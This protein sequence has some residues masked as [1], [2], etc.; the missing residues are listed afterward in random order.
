ML[1]HAADSTEPILLAARLRRIA[2]GAHTFDVPVYEHL[3]PAPRG[4]PAAL[5]LA[6]GGSSG[7]LFARLIE[8][9]AA[10]GVRVVAFDFP[11]HTPEGLLGPRTPAVHLLRNATPRVRARISRRC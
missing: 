2:C 4:A 11:G 7:V 8:R 10:R 9:A 6:G 3:E 1:V 5:C